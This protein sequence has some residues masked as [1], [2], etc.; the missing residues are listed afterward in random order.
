VSA[1]PDHPVGRPG[2]PFAF[3][4]ALAIRP[5][6]VTAQTEKTAVKATG[7]RNLMET[8]ATSGAGAPVKKS[9]EILVI[10]AS[11]VGTMFEWYDFFLYG[12][13]IANI[14][15]HFFSGVDENT[16]FIL[17][18]MAFAAGFIVRPFGGLIFGGLGDMFGRKATF[19]IALVIMG[20][21]TFA[22]GFLPD[23]NTFESWGAGMGV[24]APIILV[25]LR[26]LQGLAVG[27]Q[28]G[29]AMIY[30]AEH[31]KPGQ[32]GWAT[33]WVQIT[34]TVGLLL[35]LVL[36][37]VIQSNMTPDA[38][39]D[40]GWRIPFML[41]IFLLLVSLWIRLQLN[42]SPV[43]QKM[44]EE[45][46]TSKKPY[47]ETFKWS[48]FKYVLIALFGC[49]AGQ[50]VIWYSGTLYGLYFLQQTLKV[51]ASDAYEIMAIALGVGT[52]A[53][54]FFGWLSDKIGRKPLVL[55]GLLLPCLTYFFLFH[56][57]T[58]FAN[59]DLAA[60][61]KASPVIV[62]ADTSACSLQFDPI[63]KNKF[64]S[65]SCDIVKA[66]LAKQGVSYD[67]EKLPAGSTAQVLIGEKTVTAPDPAKVTGPERAAAIAAFQK[68]V[69]GDL[70]AAGYP[71]SVDPAKV[72]KLMII[73]IVALTTVYTA[74]VYGP[75]AAM[76]VELFPAR[77]RYTSLS[78]PYHI[79]NG[80]FGG[81][82][83]TTAFMIV[84]ATGN[85]YAGIWYPVIVAGVTFVLAI[86]LLP[87]TRGRD[88]G[89]DA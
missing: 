56:Q 37:L 23:Y 80:W 3:R 41:S 35:S 21:S 33:S 67:V 59:P 64:D 79:G 48:N 73:L 38:F 66:Y 20:A 84:A 86:F 16:G 39:A 65:K 85:I 54:L 17:A 77:I 55:A 76:L 4:L 81:L 12:S 43:Y 29:G 72:N 19:L 78:L 60:A 32:R 25:L 6:H 46:A 8:A 63:G 51:P 11:G 53:Y 26:V 9:N 28:Y 13:L 68:E 71:S 75:M 27:G 36:I 10:G 57:I 40:W 15:T 5:L 89:H 34:A 30:V 70:K 74:M 50:A 22:V 14:N 87:E 88:I 52:P 47:S 49:V 83:P 62:K 58:A 44:K 24:I 42:E 69:G 45:A 61:Q 2:E 7:E 18:L 1:L 31:S 82:L